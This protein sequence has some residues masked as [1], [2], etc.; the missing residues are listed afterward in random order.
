MGSEMCIR[1]SSSPA[2]LTVRGDQQHKATTCHCL[3]RVSR[4]TFLFPR[5][6]CL[7][8]LFSSHDCLPVSQ[9]LLHHSKSTSGSSSC[10]STRS[11]AERGHVASV[12]CHTKIT[13]SK[14]HTLDFLRLDGLHQRTATSCNAVRSNK[15]DRGQKW[16]LGTE[17]FYRRSKRRRQQA[18]HRA[19]LAHFRGRTSTVDL[20][21]DLLYLQRLANSPASCT[22]RRATRKALRIATV[23][24]VQGRVDYRTRGTRIGH[25]SCF[26]VWLTAPASRLRSV[27]SAHL[28]GRRYLTSHTSTSVHIS[29]PTH[30]LYPAIHQQPVV[31][32]TSRRET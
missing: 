26:V 4:Q 17:V 2:P 1:D 8:D 20:I 19:D 23:F 22:T 32:S 30:I 27:R 28:K 9:W 6:S 31:R 25:P 14:P 18:Q 12:F 21:S 13:T 29:P 11:E 10:R 24:S 7:D 5:S 15:N 16:L 3:I